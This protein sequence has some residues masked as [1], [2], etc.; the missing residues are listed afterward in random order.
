MK[1]NL[2]NVLLYLIELFF[3]LRLSLPQLSVCL[4]EP[5]LI[6]LTDVKAV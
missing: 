4:D 2:F 5:N 3:S 1:E 6:V